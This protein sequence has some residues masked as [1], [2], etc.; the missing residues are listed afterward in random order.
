MQV[1]SMAAL[2]S[3]SPLQS[4]SFIRRETG[5][6][7]VAIQIKYCGI[8]H[9]DIH[10]VRN[11]WGGAEYPIVPGHEITGMVTKVGS[12]V[13][14]FKVGD[15]V[16]VGC[17]VDSCRT[18]SSCQENE[19]QYCEEGMIGT[20]NSTGRDGQRTQGGY[21]SAIVVD[22]N[23]VL[24]IPDCLELDKAAPLLCAGITTYS[25]MQTFGLQKGQKLGV[26]GLG[27]LGHMAVQIGVAL[28][29]QVTVFSSTP[30][31]RESA[32]ELGAHEYITTSDKAYFTQNSSSFDLIINT[33]SAPIDQAIYLNLLRKDGTMAIVGLPDQPASFI[34]F[35]LV[36]KRRRIAGSLIGGIKETQEML[37]FCADHQ[38]GAYIETIPLSEVNK[39]YERILKNDIQYRFVID[40]E[41]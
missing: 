16:G 6:E 31:K 13:S 25:P 12:E 1:Q 38:I 11:E 14:N 2:D 4:Y 15:R 22:Q 32:M 5:P 21:S 35:P 39:A 20:Y 8:C 17:F 28:G 24:R 33:I 19:E 30:S 40:L 37:D 23:Y 9:S 3:H 29:A 36:L 7:D 41:K 27:G 18:C 26:M 34:P 10:T